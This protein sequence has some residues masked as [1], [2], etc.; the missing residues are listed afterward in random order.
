MLRRTIGL[1]T[2]GELYD[3]LLGLGM[4]IEVETLKCEDQ[5]SNSKYASA[6]LMIFF[7]HMLFLTIHLKCLYISLSG[8]GDN[9]LLHLLIEL[10]NS[11]LEKGTQTIETLLE[12]SSKTLMSIW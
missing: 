11:T 2:L 3:S 12:I 4:I 7:R 9:K 10:I 5:W 8:P 6:I 1:K